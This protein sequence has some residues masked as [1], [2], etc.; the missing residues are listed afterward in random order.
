M[1][2]KRSQVVAHEQSTLYGLIINA[3]KKI[4]YG[5]VNPVEARE[6]FIRSAL[7][8]GDFE[9][10]AD[11]FLHNRKVVEELETLEAKSRRRDIIVD[12]NVLYDFYSLHLPDN[13]VS[14]AALDKWLRAHANEARELFLTRQDLISD[15]ATLVSDD[16]FP[17]FLEM[18][19]STF[20]IEY[21]FDPRNH[22]DGITLITPAAGLNIINPQRCEWLIP[23]LLHEKV[24]ALIKSLPKQLRKTLYP[25]RILPP[26]VLRH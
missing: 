10:K 18:N 25:R 1:G 15:D 17:D 4:S 2:E 26:P 19:G 6:I 12:E 11:F 13:I 21:H 3:D 8:E 20:P 24:V 9:C 5:R 14:G 22:C 7:I 23:G 16:L